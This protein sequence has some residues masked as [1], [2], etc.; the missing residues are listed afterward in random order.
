TIDRDRFFVGHDQHLVGNNTD[1][2]WDSRLLGMDNRFAGQVAISS[3]K[4]KF[5]QT[6]FD[7]SVYSNNPTGVF[8]ADTVDVVNPDPGVFGPIANGIRDK[9][10]DTAAISFE[11]RLK[12]LP[13]LGLIGGLRFENINL[14]SSGVDSTGTDVP[15]ADFNKTWDPVSYRAGI[16]VEPIHNMMLYAMTATSYDPAEAGIFS[17]APGSSVELTK[18]RIYEVGA[19]QLLWDGK[20]EWTIAAYNILRYNVYVF[21]TNST[22]TLAG[23]VENK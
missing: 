13:W 21:L 12:P 14:R 15:G 3:K 8:P 9:H 2:T 6:D 20:A 11:D 19:K 5:T 16:T 18:A 22:A 17:I 23:Q 1:L 7:A 10:L 4:V